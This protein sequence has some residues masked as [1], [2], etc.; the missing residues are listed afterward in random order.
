MCMKLERRL[1]RLRADLCRRAERMLGTRARGAMGHPMPEDLAQMVL[2][3]MVAAY[4]EAGLAE[5]DQ[6]KLYAFA[7]TALHRLVVDEARRRVPELGKSETP[8]ET[9]LRTEAV[10]TPRGENTSALD[11][12]LEQ[13][14]PQSR[15]FVKRSVEL[16]S[17]PLAQ[18]ELGWPPGGASNAC[19][20]GKKLL[21]QLKACLESRM[22]GEHART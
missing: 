4:A 10:D 18:K 17:A 12:C 8:V 13:L 2:T 5:F 1:E 14:D 7:H 3:R 16:E 11:A 9:T 22:G 20:R 15:L 21:A 19:H 6:D